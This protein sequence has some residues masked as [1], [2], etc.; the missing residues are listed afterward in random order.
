M[1]DSVLLRFLN[2]GLINVGGDDTK[3]AKLSQAANDLASELKKSP[4]K[5]QSFSLI[6]FDPEAP[7]NDPI[8]VEALAALQARWTTYRNTFSSTP[9]A[10]IRAMLLDALVTAAEDDDRV[11]VCFVASARNALPRLQADNERDIWADVVNRIEAKVDIRAEAEWATPASVTIAPM[12]YD[13]PK[14]KALSVTAGTT[15]RD[16]LQNEMMAAAGPQYH[17]SRSG[18]AQTGGNQYW[19]QGSPTQWVSDFGRLSAAAVADAVDA[20]IAEIEITQPDLSGPLNQ[21]AKQVSSYVDDTLK[22]VSAATAGLQRRTSL[23]WWKEAL[24]SP[25]ARR[26]YRA[27]PVNV[28]AAHMA[29][30][31]FNEVPLFSPAS[32]VAFLSETV[33]QLPGTEQGKDRM[34]RE[35]VTEAQDEASLASLRSAAADLVGAPDGRGPL[36]A[37]IGHP[38]HARARAE[39]AFQ[40]LTGVPAD[41]RLDPV[42]WACWIFREL[43]A[44]KAASDSSSA[45]RRSKKG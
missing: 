33:R 30:D 32:V 20:A 3:L 42:A 6:A 31:L 14:I 4:S 39:D 25:T 16:R 35:L 5:A 19:P 43:Q 21:L 22:S 9:I 12:S 26:S 27:L 8:V 36:L 7:E 10:V 17:D 18:N 41:A 1:D 29:L 38:D 45:K 15:E 40:I 37:L 28:A 44:S 13:L 23:L 34:I 24:F 11:G 2:N